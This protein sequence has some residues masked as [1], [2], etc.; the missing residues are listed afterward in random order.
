MAQDPT[1]INFS[2]LF[3]I[4]FGYGPILTIW[5]WRNWSVYTWSELLRH[6]DCNE[7]A[8]WFHRT[9]R[10]HPGK[11]HV[12]SIKNDTHLSHLGLLRLTASLMKFDRVGIPISKYDTR[13][14]SN[15][16]SIHT[17]LPVSLITLI[18]LL[19]SIVVWGTWLNLRKLERKSVRWNWNWLKGYRVGYTNNSMTS[20]NRKAI[21]AFTYVWLTRKRG[22]KKYRL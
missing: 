1:L 10:N 7:L 17:T 13:L 12:S 2:D 16:F 8:W 4:Y 18:S 22:K 9:Q 19:I 3:R 11:I 15:N 21:N 5:K 14:V 20:L 6:K